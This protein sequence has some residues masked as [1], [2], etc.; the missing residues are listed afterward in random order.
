AH[1]FSEYRV[2]DAL[3]GR[4]GE[5][6][7]GLRNRWTLAEGVRLN[8]SFERVKAVSGAGEDDN[9]AVTAA[10]EYTRDALTKATGRVELRDGTGSR[11]ALSTLGLAHKIDEDWTLLGRNAYALTESKTGG[12]SQLQERFQLGVAYRDTRTNRVNGL[13]RY[14]FKREDNGTDFERRTVHVLSS[15]ADLQAARGLVV[16]GQY[17][18]KHGIELVEGRWIAGNAQLAS[19]RATRDFGERWDLGLAL[20]VLANANLT[21]RTASIGTEA[22]YRVVDNLWFSLGYNFTGFRDRDLVEDNTSAQGAYLRMRFKFDE[23]LF[24]LRADASGARSVQ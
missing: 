8:T 9:L 22:G 7:M 20:R 21:S 24:G 1:L 3:D 15:H 12:A 2:R 16:T 10:I 18:A 14:E 17:A 11:G 4:E 13:A 23:S 6:A 19:L 5:A